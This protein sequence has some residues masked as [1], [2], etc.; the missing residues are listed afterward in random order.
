MWRRH[1]KP[2]GAKHEVEWESQGVTRAK[3]MVLSRL[4]ESSDLVPICACSL[5]L[6]GFHKGNGTYS[7]SAPGENYLD[8]YPSSL[9]LELINS[10]LP[11]V[12]LVL[13]KLLSYT[14]A[15]SE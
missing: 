2:L 7:I 3:L 8:P 1:W 5:D 10:V 12:S 4:R 14:R 6:R 15:Q 9:V 11:H 13:F